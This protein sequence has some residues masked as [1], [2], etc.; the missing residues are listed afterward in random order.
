MTHLELLFVSFVSFVTSAE[1]LESKSVCMILLCPLVT[2]CCAMTQACQVGG[3]ACTSQ[4][5]ILVEVVGG[6]RAAGTYPDTSF[7]CGVIESLFVVGVES[8]R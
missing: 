6:S 2:Q 4:S 7:L 8:V 1:E 5:V 3:F